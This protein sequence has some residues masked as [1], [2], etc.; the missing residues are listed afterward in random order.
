MYCDGLRMAGL[1]HLRWDGRDETGKEV[2]S[3]VYICR[4]SVDRRHQY[5]KLV[6]I[7]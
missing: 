1:H 4:V 2:A 5:K 3:G 7:R 6:L